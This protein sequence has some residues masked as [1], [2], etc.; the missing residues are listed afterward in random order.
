MNFR[1][2]A[3]DNRAGGGGVELDATTRDRAAPAAGPVRGHRAQHGG[4]LGGRPAADGHLERGRHRRSRPSSTAQRQHL[5]LH[6]RRADVPDRARGEHAERRL[7]DGHGAQR[8]HHDRARQGRGGGQHLLRHLRRRTSR[9]QPVALPLAQP[10]SLVVD[11][12]GNGVL[13]PGE[14]AAV[15]PAWRNTE[16]TALA[17]RRRCAPN[18]TRPRWA[19]PTPSPTRPPRYGTIRVRATSCTADGRLLRA[20][21]IRRHASRASTGT[22]PSRRR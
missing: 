15:A 17:D 5:A 6:R 14:T 18:F 4:H 7:A 1:V 3:R 12:A 8:Q 19:R 9:S 22:P 20:S 16:R 21:A 11:A 13:Q 2:T 10:A